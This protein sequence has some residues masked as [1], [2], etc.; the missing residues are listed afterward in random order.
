MYFVE[1]YE[2]AEI[3]KNTREYFEKIPRVVHFLK[4]LLYELT[5]GLYVSKAKA[6]DQQLSIQ[7]YELYIHEVFSN[8]ISLILQLI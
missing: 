1:P 7:T 8:V 5:H 3:L 4:F 6:R 2:H